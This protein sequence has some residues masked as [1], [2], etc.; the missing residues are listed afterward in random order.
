MLPIR[1]LTRT[2]TSKRLLP[3]LSSQFSTTSHAARPS[4]S[5]IPS[6]NDPKNPNQPHISNVHSTLTGDMPSV[7]KAP[8]PPEFI[9]SVDPKYVTKSAYPTTAKDGEVSGSTKS[10]HGG[11]VDASE[12]EWAKFI[13][14]PIKRVGEDDKTMRARLVYQSRKRGILET[15]L[16]L[17][18]FADENLSRMTVAQMQEY[19]S[20]LDENDWDIYYWCTQDAPVNV[21][22]N[23]D[24]S[25]DIPTEDGSAVTEATTYNTSSSRKTASPV[26]PDGKILPPPGVQHLGSIE[27][28]MMKTNRDPEDIT[29]SRAI[30][31][32][33]T[34]GSV[35]IAYKPV[36]EKWKNSWVLQAIRDHV[37]SRRARAGDIDNSRLKAKGMGRM[38][39]LRT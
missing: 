3:A 16:L 15:D 24:S 28:P 17:S 4:R 1:S 33:Q 26:H 21:V 34:V 31:W 22:D 14:E 37:E 11:A 18:T 6:N 7:G 32:A 5:D 38:P 13:A 19:D 27:Q 36:P 20:F 25:A 30:E 35:K 9:G 29:G 23:K 10:G 2:L 39:D 8:P 12:S